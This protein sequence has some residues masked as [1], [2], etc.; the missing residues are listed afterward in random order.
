MTSYLYWLYFFGCCAYVGYG[1]H[2]YTG[3][4][5][6]AAEW[7]MS[8]VGSYS[9]KLILLLVAVAAGAGC[10]GYSCANVAF[11][12]FDLS[13]GRGPS[14]NH[15]VMTG[16]AHTEYQVEFQTKS[17]GSPSL[18]R[19]IPIAAADWRRVYFMKTNASLHASRGRQV[20]QFL[21]A[22][23]ACPYDDQRVY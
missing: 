12:V 10:Y 13:N 6:L 1:W 2:S 17:G 19:Y 11:E 8:A 23:A 3:L 16:V 21:A 4:Y 5:R 14:S 22:N 7:Q 9:V 15:V 20:L 18:D